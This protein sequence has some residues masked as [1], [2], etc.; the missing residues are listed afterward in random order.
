MSDIRAV[1]LG[2]DEAGEFLADPTVV[3]QD[4]RESQL[5]DLGD[6]RRDLPQDRSTRW[7]YYPWRRTLVGLLGPESFRRL[8]LDRNRN[9]IT[10]DEQ[11]RF[12]GLT[13]AVAGLSVGHSIAHTLVQEGLCGRIR[14]ADFDVIEVSNLNRIPA[15]V[16]DIGLNK[17]VVAARRL[18]ELDPYLEVEAH[19]DGVQ[20]ADVDA[21]LDGVDVL[22]EEADSLD[23]KVLLREQARAR[24]IP[25]LMATSDRGLVDVERFDLEPDRPLFHGLAGDLDSA[26]L[27]GL[28]TRDKA[29]HVARIIGAADLSA[30]FAASMVEVDTSLS[31]WPQLA[32]DV[33]LGAATVAAAV[34]RFGLGQPLPSGRCRIDLDDHLA[35]LSLP[36][37]PT[38]PSVPAP[39]TSS[40]APADDDRAAILE[41]IGRAPSG[42]NVQPWRTET[43]ADEVR[44]FLDRTR[45][46]TMDVEFRGSLVA[47]GAALF[48]AR[49]VAAQRARLGTAEIAI[50]EAAGPDDLVARLRLGTGTDERL[51]R[52]DVLARGTNRGRGDARPLTTYQ[53]YALTESAL[54]EGG[55]CHLVER[56]PLLDHLGEL[57]ARAD[58][59]RYLT[60]TLHREMFA[61]LVMSGGPRAEGIDVASLAL[62]EA[63]LAKLTTAGRPEVMAL[64]ADWDAGAALGD[65]TRERVASSSGLAVVAVEGRGAADFV[66]GG[67]AVESVWVTAESLGLAVHPVSPVFLY[68]IDDAGRAEL[69]PRYADELAVLQGG[70]RDVVGLVDGESIAL[71]LRLSHTGAA[72]VRSLRRPITEWH[73][74]A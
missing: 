51:Q 70:F 69:S 32:S 39:R 3:V 16:L 55:R 42:G 5:A 9:K 67:Q 46:T 49:V 29:P 6:L 68:G 44:L 24:G 8:R 23:V 12:D 28:T 1:V 36:E 54:A 27:R 63:D 53:R 33:V 48:N 22:I 72:P 17:A 15:T 38:G 11:R 59:V 50:S 31:T 35:E 57:L 52:L 73:R 10:G 66:R 71:V 40:E 18:A 41:A 58:R 61:E 56:G 13:V 60:E 74:T 43:T 20:P 2:D 34:R 26:S 65:D 14:L 64:L 37:E 25:V 7:V 21:F 4:R 62:D 45:T 30:R 47:L 19:E